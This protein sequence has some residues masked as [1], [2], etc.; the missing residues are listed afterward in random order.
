VALIDDAGSKGVQFVVFPELALSPY[1]ATNVRLRHHGRRPAGL[2]ARGWDLLPLSA[3]PCHW[4][5]NPLIAMEPN[6]LL[7]EKRHASGFYDTNRDEKLKALGVDTLLMCG[8][9]TSGCVRSRAVDGAAG[10]SA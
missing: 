2:A 9:S 4:A 5:I 3:R 7:V 10:R 6:D 1:F 8:M